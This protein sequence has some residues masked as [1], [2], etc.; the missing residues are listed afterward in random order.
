MLIIR[1]A[2]VL[3]R[4]LLL[5]YANATG[6]HRIHV[7]ASLALD[8]CQPDLSLISIRWEEYA[9]ATIAS[10]ITKNEHCDEEKEAMFACNVA[11][12]FCL[13]RL[14]SER[15]IFPILFLAITSMMAGQL[16]IQKHR[17]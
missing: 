7:E 3:G 10:A 14:L 4:H 9:R 6:A 17:L 1:Y 15:H 13:V 12:T 2:G 16:L 11:G 8:P 5:A